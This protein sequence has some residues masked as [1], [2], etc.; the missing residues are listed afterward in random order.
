MMPNSTRLEVSG[1]NLMVRKSMKFGAAGNLPHYMPI[2][3]QCLEHRHVGNQVKAV[4]IE[5]NT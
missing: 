1:E 5:T 3:G 4:L 2:D